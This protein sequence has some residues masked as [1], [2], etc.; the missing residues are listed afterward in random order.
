MIQP[1]TAGIDSLRETF[2][3]SLG[4]IEE[5]ELDIAA[6]HSTSLYILPEYIERFHQAYPS[7]RINLHNYSMPA[8]LKP[9]LEDQVDFA[10]GSLPQVPENIIYKPFVGFKSILITSLD[11]PLAHK[12]K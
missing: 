4:K 9:L 2:A 3:A 12:N 5:G 6:G 10:V 7:I 1:L 11:H 8:G